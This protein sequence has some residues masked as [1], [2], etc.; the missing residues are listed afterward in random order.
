MVFLEHCE[1]CPHHVVVRQSPDRRG[2]S[3]TRRCYGL[4]VTTSPRTRAQR[5]PIRSRIF[6]H[7]RASVVATRVFEHCEACPAPCGGRTVTRSMRRVANA[8]LYRVLAPAPGAE[9]R[10][11]ADT[12]RYLAHW[13]RY[14][15]WLLHS[16]HPTCTILNHI[17]QRER[18][19]HLSRTGEEG[20][21]RNVFDISLRYLAVSLATRA[22]APAL[23]HGKAS[24]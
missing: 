18:E 13:S 9:S 5:R 24:H 3:L 12:V 17:T 20:A 15:T 4:T 2:E 14:S 11:I 1:A 8:T 6:D 19:N 10:G 7:G 22:P 16:A 23:K 21:P